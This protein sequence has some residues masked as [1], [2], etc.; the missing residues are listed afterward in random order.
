[1]QAE[2]GR[3]IYDYWR[4]SAMT[5]VSGG[6]VLFIAVGREVEMAG[7]ADERST[8]WPAAA[9]VAPATE[10]VF[11]E[12]GSEA[13]FLAGAWGPTWQFGTADL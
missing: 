6:E 2:A 8:S 4:R 12:S 1:M 10:F 13:G 5:W 7:N 9:A 11:S 3:V